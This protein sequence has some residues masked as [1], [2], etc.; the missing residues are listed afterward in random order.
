VRNNRFSASL[1]SGNIRRIWYTVFNIVLGG[2]ALV[3]AVIS[4][5]RASQP[6]ALYFYIVGLL[7]WVFGL[8]IFISRPDDNIAQL[9]YL[10]SVGVMSTCSV[11]ATFS[12]MEQGWQAKFVPLFQFIFAAFLPCLFL[13]CCSAF[14]C[15]VHLISG[16]K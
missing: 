7:T 13:R 14:G 12:A 8:G 16:W 15:Y 4:Y 11:D 10:M 5:G 2:M 9:S 3:A 6:D 1:L